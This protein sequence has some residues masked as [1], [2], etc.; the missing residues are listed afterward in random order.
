M[1]G[2]GLSPPLVDTAP[3]AYPQKTMADETCKA[4]QI[5]WVLALMLINKSKKKIKLPLK[6][7]L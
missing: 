1:W 4:H 2:K 6:R 3:K 5:P 7:R